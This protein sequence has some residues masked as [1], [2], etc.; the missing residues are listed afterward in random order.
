MIPI[1]ISEYWFTITNPITNKMT[2]M[3]IKPREIQIGSFMTN[4]TNLI[5]SRKSKNP[6]GK[7]IKNCVKTNNEITDKFNSIL[8]LDV[9]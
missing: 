9:D 5:F 8:I 2:L 7:D 3:I 1:T 4:G 6:I